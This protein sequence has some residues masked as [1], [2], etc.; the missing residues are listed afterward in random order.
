MSCGFWD[1]S[2]STES[3]KGGGSSAGGGGG[4]ELFGQPG[5]TTAESDPVWSNL[6][7][8]CWVLWIEDAT[9]MSLTNVVYHVLLNLVNVMFHHFP[10]V[11]SKIATG[12]TTAMAA[13]ASVWQRLQRHRGRPEMGILRDL[14]YVLASKQQQF[15]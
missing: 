4:S 13:M 14:P 6:T 9:F 11:F 12:T 10:Q 8:K 15:F 7:P 2:D 3:D 1:S 5:G